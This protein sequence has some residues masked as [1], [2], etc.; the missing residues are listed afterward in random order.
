MEQS[1]VRQL[2]Y[3]WKLCCLHAVDIFLDRASFLVC[4]YHKFILLRS[5]SPTRQTKSS[6]ECALRF[7]TRIKGTRDG[8][9][10]DS[11][12]FP[13]VSWTDW[14]TRTRN[15]PTHPL[16]YWSCIAWFDHYRSFL[17]IRSAYTERRWVSWFSEVKQ[18]PMDWWPLTLLWFVAK[19][20]TK[21]RKRWPAVKSLP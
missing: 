7:T 18:R 3:F 13:S 8:A 15:T 17:L 6:M 20:T 14:S 1:F 21:K 4:H 9:T 12:L 16:W 19:R 11:L 5:S 10:E 2:N